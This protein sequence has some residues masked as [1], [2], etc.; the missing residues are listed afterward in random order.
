[1]KPRK[2]SI[3]T[4][5]FDESSIEDEVNKWISEKKKYSSEDKFV[6]MPYI[7]KLYIHKNDI[8]IF[9][10]FEYES[11][12]KINE[13]YYLPI[14][15]VGWDG[16]KLICYYYDDHINNLYCV[17]INSTMG[18]KKLM[19]EGNIIKLVSLLHQTPALDVS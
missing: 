6:F 1:M 8:H 10:C 17:H 11:L 13:E 9:N 5:K 2:L 19:V 7:K 12:E 18:N 3:L 14:K 16:T 15:V 4:E